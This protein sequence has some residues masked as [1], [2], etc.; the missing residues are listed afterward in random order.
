MSIDQKPFGEAV[1]HY[2]KEEYRCPKKN[3]RP[4][5]E[6][7]KK[8][9]VKIIKE[10]KPSVLVGSTGVGGVFDE[11]TLR[12]MK[13]VNWDRDDGPRQ[14]PI[15]F[16]LSNPMSS[17]ECKAEDAY[18][19]TD[20]TAIFAAG[21]KMRDYEQGDG[22]PTFHPS[23]A[24]NFFVFPGVGY[25]ASFGSFSKGVPEEVFL[26]ASQT[27]ASMVTEEEVRH[28]SVLPAVKRILQING[29]V[30]NNI[31]AYGERLKAQF[32]EA[33]DPTWIKASSASTNG[34]GGVLGAGSREPS[35]TSLIV[36]L[37]V[38]VV[39][40][41]VGGYLFG[42]HKA[43]SRAVSLRGQSGE[44]REA[45]IELGTA[46]RKSPASRYPDKRSDAGVSLVANDSFDNA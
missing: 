19:Y 7:L 16:A 9:Q 22:K 46:Q 45:G 44:L 1:P 25:G 34:K 38:F 10:F 18:K 35:N 15:I 12:A 33:D 17:A 2:E 5:G 13:A 23:Q 36:G 8:L 6:C 43:N 39:V 11:E 21:T 41:S 29:A 14:H 30:S 4:D 20:G 26:V 24:N 28:G 42:M 27:L 3:F 40:G 32:A 37:I 31:L